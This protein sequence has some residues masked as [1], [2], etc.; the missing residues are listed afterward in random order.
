MS[1]AVGDMDLNGTLDIV[2]ANY[3]GQNAVYLND[4]QGNYTEKRLFGPSPARTVAVAAADVDDDG[5]LDIVSAGDDGRNA[6]YLNDGEGNFPLEPSQAL[7]A[8]DGPASSLAIG[9][10]NDDSAF[11]LV[12]GNARA[13]PG[14]FQ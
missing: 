13:Q 4:G 6:I 5:D 3:G 14:L 11:D 12:I 1:V 8:T 10:L 2:A 9:D 7:A